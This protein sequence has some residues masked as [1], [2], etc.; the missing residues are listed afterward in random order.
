MDSM[1]RYEIDELQRKLDG[2]PPRKKI[3]LPASAGMTKD[4]AVKSALK[5]FEKI[6][7]ENK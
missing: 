1:H 4:E 2:K 6:Q 5:I 7:K 3:V